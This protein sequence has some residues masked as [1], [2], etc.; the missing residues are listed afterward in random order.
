MEVSVGLAHV[1]TFPQ[2]PDQPQGRA[3]GRM[4]WTY[5]IENWPI[6]PV[7]AAE[8]CEGPYPPSVC[9]ETSN[10]KTWVRHVDGSTAGM[11]GADVAKTGS[12]VM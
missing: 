8:L 9:P 6:N 11:G 4:K 2:E 10:R 7:D 1:M 5:P 3:L 12:A